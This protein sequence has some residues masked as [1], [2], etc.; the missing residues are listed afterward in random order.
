VKPNDI[1]KHL[2]LNS[3]TKNKNA[4]IKI[5]RSKD[6]EVYYFQELFRI[7]EL[8]KN[9]YIIKPTKTSGVDD[10]LSKQIKEFGLKTK[11]WLQE[12]FNKVV[13]SKVILKE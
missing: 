3:K 4:K 5:Q 2:D 12:M 13:K 9:I 1:A 7:E 6:N 10:I 11:D 8:N